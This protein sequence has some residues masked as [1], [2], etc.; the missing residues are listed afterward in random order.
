MPQI[1]V[2]ALTLWHWEVGP[3]G[4]VISYIIK[5]LLLLSI[6]N[7]TEHMYLVFNHF[8]IVKLYGIKLK[9]NNKKPGGDILVHANQTFFPFLSLTHPVPNP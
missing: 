3:L 6:Q 2:E 8:P 5:D 9:N 1:H 7:S 4:H